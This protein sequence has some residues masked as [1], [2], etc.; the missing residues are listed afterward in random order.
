[1]ART[2][3]LSMAIVLAALVV[4]VLANAVL[5]LP[6]GLGMAGGGGAGAG[7]RR[8]L[9][10][11]STLVTGDTLTDRLGGYDA[12]TDTYHWDKYGVYVGERVAM[13]LIV[14]VLTVLFIPFFLC[15]RCCCNV[16]GGRKPSYGI[17]RGPRERATGVVTQSNNGVVRVDG[18]RV[19]HTDEH[20]KALESGATIGAVAPKTYSRKTVMVIKFVAIGFV[21]AAVI[22]GSVILGGNALVSKGIDGL[23][24]GVIVTGEELVADVQALVDELAKL[25]YTQDAATT[26]RSALDEAQDVLK[27]AKSVG[28]AYVA[29]LDKYRFYFLVICFA[30]PLALLGLGLGLGILGCTM[31]QAQIII[32]MLML[33]FMFLLWGSIAIHVLFSILFGDVCTEVSIRT[34]SDPSNTIGEAIGCGSTNEAFKSL[35]DEAD[36]GLSQAT[37]AACDGAAQIC[38]DPTCGPCPSPC[39]G[40]N[41]ASH[42]NVTIDSGS[43]GIVTWSECASVCENSNRKDSTAAFAGHI[44]VR[45]SYVGIRDRAGVI[46]EC[47]FIDKLVARV[48]NALCSDFLG[49]VNMVLYGQIVLAVVLTGGAVVLI[50]GVKRFNRSNTRGFT[51]AAVAPAAVAEY[52]SPPGYSPAGLSPPPNYSHSADDSASSH[53]WGSQASCPGD[54]EAPSTELGGFDPSYSTSS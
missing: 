52:G 6:G 37:N 50:M 2:R 5:P 48:D 7:G 49:G 28:R 1:M 15:C 41:V 44:A 30:V 4:N 45:T 22:S 43:P 33:L 35:T 11:R 42:L 27:N 53:N 3:C 20:V 36:S 13:P 16:C 47:G 40:D 34:G 23:V 38:T 9:G 10:S 17:C 26:T 21:A 54:D 12:E 51:A 24:D 32:A 14:G 31:C 39:T 29:E 46:L 25:P 18:K 19:A 8:L